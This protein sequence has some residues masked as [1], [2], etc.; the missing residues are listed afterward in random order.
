MHGTWTEYGWVQKPQECSLIS[1]QQHVTKQSEKAKNRVIK[2]T[3][4]KWKALENNSALIDVARGTLI[5]RGVLSNLC[6]FFIQKSQNNKSNLENLLKFNLTIWIMRHWRREKANKLILFLVLF[7]FDLVLTNKVSH[8]N[9]K[10]WKKAVATFLLSNC[11]MYFFY[12]LRITKKIL[13]PGENNS[14]RWK[15]AFISIKSSF[16]YAEGWNLFQ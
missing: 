8:E 3:Y 4:K 13:K 6:S 15:I 9:E 5:A 2:A 7:S 10:T 1:Y 11:F 16:H 14:S 12:I